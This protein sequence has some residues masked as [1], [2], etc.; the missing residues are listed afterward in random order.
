MVSRSVCLRATLK[1]G[2]VRVVHRYGFKVHDWALSPHDFDALLRSFDGISQFRES[3][4]QRILFRNGISGFRRRDDA[5]VEA[6]RR[7]AADADR[8]RG[9]QPDEEAI[10][11]RIHNT[12]A[13]APNGE[14]PPEKVRSCA[15]RGCVLKEPPDVRAHP[16]TCAS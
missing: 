6:E 5:D 9:L 8:L 3:Q 10:A 15:M 16:Q 14:D 13:L 7:A 2:T 1:C 4:V 11:E 12:V